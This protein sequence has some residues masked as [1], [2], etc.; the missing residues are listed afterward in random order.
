[1]GT[2]LGMPI[3]G[4]LCQIWGWES[5]FYFFG[6]NSHCLEYT[7]LIFYYIGFLLVVCHTHCM[8]SLRLR[9]S[10]VLFRATVEAVAGMLIHSTALRPITTRPSVHPQCVCSVCRCCAATVVMT[11]EPCAVYLV[12]PSLCV[13]F[14]RCHA[15][16]PYDRRHRVAQAHP[17]SQ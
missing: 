15:S 9:L 10:F 1:M 11:E 4:F 2:V 14:S 13:C 7:V 8:N 16:S 12:V 6:E 17:P 5:V 3:S